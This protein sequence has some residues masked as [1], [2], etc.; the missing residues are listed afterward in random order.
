[1]ESIESMVGWVEAVDIEKPEENRVATVGVNEKPKRLSLSGELQR[2]L[3]NPEPLQHPFHRLRDGQARGIEQ[4]GI[5][6]LPQGG[7]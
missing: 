2:C 4:L 1:M 3:G 7:R 5:R 6:R